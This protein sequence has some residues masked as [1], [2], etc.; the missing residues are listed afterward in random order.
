MTAEETPIEAIALQNA[1]QHPMLL[2]DAG[3]NELPA[4][5]V[6]AI[7][8]VILGRAVAPLSLCNLLVNQPITPTFVTPRFSMAEEA[9]CECS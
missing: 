9:S 6:A 7:L 4:T 2:D 8:P 1:T 5:P 3:L